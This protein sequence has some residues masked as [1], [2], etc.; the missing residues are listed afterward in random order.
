MPAVFSAIRQT[1]YVTQKLLYFQALVQPSSQLSSKPSSQ[2]SNQRSS[3]SSNVGWELNQTSN[4]QVNYPVSHL[5]Y[6]QDSQDLHVCLCF[7]PVGDGFHN[8]VRRFPA[9]VN[10]TVIDMFQP[11]SKYALFS[12]EK[13]FLSTVDLGTDKERDVIEQFLPFSFEA[14]N[15]T[16]IK[17]WKKE[18]RIVYTTPKSYLELIKLYTILLEDSQSDAV[19]IHRKGLFQC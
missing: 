14:V 5:V 3:Q 13:K 2:Q 1:Y 4:L 9:V 11:W 7:S 10:C 15:K 19:A 18:W 12:V 17:Y 8:Q 16:T 6:L